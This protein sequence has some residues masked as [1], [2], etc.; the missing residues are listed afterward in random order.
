MDGCR[1]AAQI[2]DGLTLVLPKVILS[3]TIDLQGVAVAL[4][5][6]FH[7]ARLLDGLAVLTPHHLR[8]WPGVDNAH[9]LHLVPLTSAHSCL[10]WMEAASD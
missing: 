7:L 3:D 4:V 9:Q 2:I 8:C 10:R 6:F 1:G 5:M